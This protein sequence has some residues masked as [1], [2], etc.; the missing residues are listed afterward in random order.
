MISR[1]RTAYCVF[2]GMHPITNLDDQRRTRAKTMPALDRSVRSLRFN[3]ELDTP[4]RRTGIRGSIHA[5][6]ASEYKFGF[7]VDRLGGEL[8][9]SGASPAHQVHSTSED[10]GR[11]RPELLGRRCRRHW[12]RGQRH[13]KFSGQ[14]LS[15]S[16]VFS[17]RSL[18]DKSYRMSQIQA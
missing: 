15:R 14:C 11:G 10:V 17:T 16:K 9:P 18:Q 1:A 3:K 4:G 7:L 2:W 12:V 8:N 5:Q 13:A 6:S